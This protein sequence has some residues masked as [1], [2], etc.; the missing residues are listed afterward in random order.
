MKVDVENR[1]AGVRVAI[2]DR[3]ISTVRV[4]VR[5]RNRGGHS[6]HPAYKRVVARAEVV[7]AGD[8]P[9]WHHEHVRGRLR[10]DVLERDDLIV[11]MNDGCRNLS[12]DDPAEKTI[13]HLTS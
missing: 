3:A 8:M 13:R 1:L 2:E 10:R 4:P 7:E 12:G 5:F 9:A 11:L 6:H